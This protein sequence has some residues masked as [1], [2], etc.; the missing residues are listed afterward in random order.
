MLTSS[1]CIVSVFTQALRR[2]QGGVGEDIA[3]NLTKQERHRFGV[4][5]SWLQF[6]FDGKHPTRPHAR[7]RPRSHSS[8]AAL[9]WLCPVPCAVALTEALHE[10]GWKNRPAQLRRRRLC[11]AEGRAGADCEI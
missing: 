3:L 5:R 4:V 8:I 9:E 2:R 7:K 1:P 10:V 11:A 6:W